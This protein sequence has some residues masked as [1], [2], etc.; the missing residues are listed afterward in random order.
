[1]GFGDGAAPPGGGRTTPGPRRAAAG[2]GQRAMGKPM[3]TGDPRMPNAVRK[4]VRPPPPKEEDQPPDFVA[5]AGA[6]FGMGGTI[7]RWKVR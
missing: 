3:P 1:M 4:Y 6:I 5:I 7:M 2:G